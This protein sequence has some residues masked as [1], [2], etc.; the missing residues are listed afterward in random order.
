VSSYLDKHIALSQ[1]NGTDLK[2]QQFNTTAKFVE[3]NFSDSPFYRI[4]KIN[5]TVDLEVRIKDISAV[6]RSA[7][8]SLVQNV[9]K[10]MLL[11][12]NTTVNIGDMVELDGHYWMVTDFISD[13]PLFP[14]AKIGKC[15][16]VL[17]LKT[18][19]TKTVIGYDNLKRP[20][21]DIQETFVDI[22]CILQTSVSNAA[23]NQAINLP[24][25]Q[26]H[27]TMQ[28]ND[29]AKSIKENDDFDLYDRQYKV[30]GFDFSSIVQGIGCVAIIAERVV[31]T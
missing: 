31:N 24:Q 16:Y 29:I 30:I 13:N 26:V 7:N 2:Q 20:Q 5:G 19:E 28:Y 4:V 21:Y 22:Q 25:G 12:P 17:H 18:G 9:L 10:F 23:L 15:N 14:K 11:K 27:I 6:T 1:I 3:S 8:V